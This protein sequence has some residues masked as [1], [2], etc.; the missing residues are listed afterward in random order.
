MLFGPSVP[1]GLLYRADLITGD[2]EQALVAHFTRLTFARVEM[3]GVVARRRT[4]HY[5]WTY[6]YYSRRSEP[7]PPLPDFLS[8]PRARVAAWAGIDPELFV[9]ALI[10]EYTPGSTIGWHRDAPMFGDVIGGISL[11]AAARM[12]FRPYVS[13]GVPPVNAAARAHA[14]RKTTHVL[15]LAPR[16]GY[17]ITGVARREFEHSIP[18]VEALRYS[19]TFR[20]VRR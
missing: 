16:S 11:L 12:K 7:G 1:D 5:G 4:L 9:E 3:R 6:G 20:T 17:L 2:E 15:T 14:P 8:A 19:I 10:T 13:P 18:A